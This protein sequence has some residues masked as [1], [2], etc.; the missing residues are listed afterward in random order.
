MASYLI[1]G[2]D[3]AF[4][5]VETGPYA[6]LPQLEAGIRTLGLDPENLTDILLTHIHLDHAGNAGA[7]ARRYGANVWV[8]E[9]GAG[10]LVDPERLISSSRRVYGDRFD[11]LMKGAEPLPED[12]LIEIQDGDEFELHGH[13]FRVVHTPGH[14][15]SHVS[16]LMDGRDLFTGDSAGIRF[17]GSAIVK[18]ATA[19][20]EIDLDAWLDSIMRMQKLKPERLLLTHYGEFTDVDRHFRELRR[21]HALWGR[22]ILAGLRLDEDDGQLVDRI[23]EVAEGQMQAADLSERD[24]ERYRVSSDHTMT[25]AGLARYW[26]KLRPERLQETRFPLDRPA[27]LAVLAS[28]RGSNFAALAQAYPHGDPLGSVDLLVSDQAAAG[29]FEIA[30]ARDIPAEHVPFSSRE[31]FE[32]ELELLL[33]ERHI[34]LVCLAGFMRL[35]SAGFVERWRGRLLNIHPSL[36]PDFPGLDPQ[37]QAL[38]AGAAETG[39]S[40]HFVDAGMDTGPVISQVRVQ[41]A[42]GD[43]A[44]SLARRIREQEHTL[45]PQAVRAVLRGTAA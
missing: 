25:A 4:M 29:A 13:E 34:D 8:H 21:Q 17:P 22:T 9:D 33:S 16:F 42:A 19:P 31:S 11:E 27:R 35:L 18:P 7:L 41:I 26:R 6:L 24:R 40:V 39:C 44:D 45:Y 15:G 36:L 23:S 10:F 32:T 2:E 37:Q 38:D 1:K 14:A 30:A 12:N 43:D 28:G 3:G 5:L 20:P